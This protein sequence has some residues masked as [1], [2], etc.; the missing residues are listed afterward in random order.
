MR[1]EGSGIGDRGSG[2]IPARSLTP[3]PRS[4][5]PPLLMAGGGT[6]GHVIPALAV[7]RELRKRGHAVFFVGTERGLEAK[8]VPAEGFEL[9]RIEVGGLN[10]V[11]LRQ[12]LATLV[13]LPWTTIGCFRFVRGA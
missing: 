9:K 3:D 11:G 5:T 6:G 2:G 8:L 12:K 7:A 4:L 10:Q 1:D 13:R